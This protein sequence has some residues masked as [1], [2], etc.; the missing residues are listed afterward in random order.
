M[1]HRQNTVIR[2]ILTDPNN[3]LRQN[4]RSTPSVYVFFQ[5]HAVVS[6][7]FLQSRYSDRLSIRLRAKDGVRVGPRLYHRVHTCVILEHAHCF[8]SVGVKFFWFKQWQ[9][10]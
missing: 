5:F 9:Y 10:K 3:S 7:M 8:A 1:R 4:I 6:T 2:L